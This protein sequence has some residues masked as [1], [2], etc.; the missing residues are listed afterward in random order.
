MVSPRKETTPKSPPKSPVR[1]I[2]KNKPF[3]NKN[4][5]KQ[6]SS[7]ERVNGNYITI[8]ATRGDE[9]AI[10]ILKGDDEEV[11]AYVLNIR[12]DIDANLEYIIDLCIGSCLPRRLSRDNNVVALSRGMSI[13]NCNRLVQIYNIN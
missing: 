12:D 4:P 10:S 6:K 8:T 9:E 5:Y 11:D 2:R 3:S 7:S 13:L 1:A